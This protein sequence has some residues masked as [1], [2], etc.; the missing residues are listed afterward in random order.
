[1]GSGTLATATVVLPDFLAGVLT[2]RK[3]RGKGIW[4]F[5]LVVDIAPG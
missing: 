5:E 1:M 2:A 3:L 4:N